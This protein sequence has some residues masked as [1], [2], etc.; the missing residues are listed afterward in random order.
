[1]AKLRPFV[2][3]PL[4]GELLDILRERFPKARIELNGYKVGKHECYSV[5]ALY[6]GA[7]SRDL[8]DCLQ[9]LG[10]TYGNIGYSIGPGRLT[11]SKSTKEAP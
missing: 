4:I 5:D 2:R 11:K 10:W 9:M 7:D 6:S 8:F 3:H 1:M